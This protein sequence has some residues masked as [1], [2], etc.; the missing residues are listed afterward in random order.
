MSELDHCLAH[1]ELLSDFDRRLSVIETIIGAN[2]TEGLRAQISELAA[3]IRELTRTLQEQKIMEA[4]KS[5]RV[6]GATWVGRVIWAVFGA[7]ILA[8]AT[9]WFSGLSTGK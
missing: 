7:G 4:E 6:Q 2:G 3:Q 5:G 8:L 9:N 1:R